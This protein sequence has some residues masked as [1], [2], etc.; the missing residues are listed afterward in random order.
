MYIKRNHTNSIGMKIPL[1]YENGKT[2]SI[3]RVDLD[4]LMSLCN[5]KEMFALKDWIPEYRFTK[6]KLRKWT[7]KNNPNIQ[8]VCYKSFFT[9][10]F[11]RKLEDIK[12]IDP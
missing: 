8:P 2:H 9:Q 7:I 12:D 10:S 1:E 6:F 3:R 4:E 5:N 11:P